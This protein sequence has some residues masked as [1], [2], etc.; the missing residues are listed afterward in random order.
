M[1]GNRFFVPVRIFL[2][3][4][5]LLYLLQFFLGTLVCR[6]V[7]HHGNGV[8]V[9]H[10]VIIKDEDV[11]TALCIRLVVALAIHLL[12]A[13][14]VALFRFRFGFPLDL[15]HTRYVLESESGSQQCNLHLAT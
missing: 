3:R 10:H 15:R 8:V 12:N 13:F 9:V 5:L 4:I 7:L 14:Q 11:G 2:L 6:R 1:I